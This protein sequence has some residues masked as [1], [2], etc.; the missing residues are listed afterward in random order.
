MTNELC[1]EKQM[2]IF[3][4]FLFLVVLLCKPSKKD[5]EIEA[6]EFLGGR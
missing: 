4:P 2:S 5:N 6:W 1:A 3:F